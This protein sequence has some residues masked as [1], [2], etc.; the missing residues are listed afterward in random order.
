[1]G[2]FATTVSNDASLDASSVAARLSGTAGIVAGGDMSMSAGGGAHLEAD[3][4]LAAVR[5]DID[6]TGRAVHLSGT[7][8]MS[9]MAGDIDVKTPGSIRLQ[10]EGSVAE[11]TGPETEFVTFVWRSNA[12]FEQHQ[13]I[14]PE[15]V[16]EVSEV[17]I[18]A[19]YSD[20]PAEVVADTHTTVGLSLGEESG[21]QL[22]WKMVWTSTDQGAY[23]MDGLTV[24]LEAPLDVAAIR[25]SSFG[26]DGR[27]F[28]GW[29]R[30]EILLGRPTGGGM[31][32]ASASN[33]EASVAGGVL[34]TAD[35]V[36]MSSAKMLEV[37]AESTRVT[38]NDIGV[39]AASNLEAAA[40]TLNVEVSDEIDVWGG[41]DVSASVGAVNAEARGD[42]SLAAAGSVSVSGDEGTV[43]LSGKLDATIEELKLRTESGASMSATSVS[44]V[45]DDKASLHAAEASVSVSGQL[46]AFMEEG[47]I[48]AMGDLSVRSGGK[49]KM[50][51]ETVQLESDMMKLRVPEK[52]DTTVGKMKFHAQSEETAAKRVKMPFDCSLLPGGCDSLSNA[53]SPEVLQELA[54]LL[55]VPLDR[56]KVNIRNPNSGDSGGGGSGRRRMKTAPTAVHRWTVEEVSQWLAELGKGSGAWMAIA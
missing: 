27:T 38:S 18:R 52:M 5:G 47:D 44:A 54:E 29:S 3:S 1:M 11:M 2:D 20:S 32:V 13:N 51:S 35:T 42:A 48:L 31:R 12:D 8:E 39:R 41:G 22:T 30:V 50:R 33:L 21:S 56:L 7:E 53:D 46:D 24:G 45:A 17:V 16:T 28:R 25:L 55:G 15:A 14:L 23:S 19:G 40:E 9:V 26:G 4:I 37:G 6:A 49:M 10:G 34:L 36:Q 43:S